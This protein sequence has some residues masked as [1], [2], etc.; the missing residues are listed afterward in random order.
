VAARA[1]W[2]QY[3]A[4]LAAFGMRPGLERVAAL[5]EALGRPQDTFRAVHIVGTNGKSS[6]TRYVAAILQAAGLQVGAYLSPHISGFAERV[7]IGGQ[8]IEEAD[9]GHAVEQV[10]A[11]THNLPEELGETTQFE[12]LTVA[13]LLAFAEAGVEAAAVE[14][15]LGGRLDATNVLLAPVV[16]LTNVALEHADVLGNTREL[17]FAEKAAVIKGGD[18]VFGPLDSLEGVARAVCTAAHARPYF[19]GFDVTVEG[20]PRRFTV[21]TPSGP[22]EGLSVPT[23]ALYQLTNAALA[24][25]AAEL[26]L[27]CHDAGVVR[28]ALGGAA[29]PGRLQVTHRHPLVLADG[30]HNPAG[31]RSLLAS[32]AFIDWPR[33]RVAVLAIMRDK[34]FA[35]MLALLEPELDAL[36]CTQATE[37][38]SLSA[39]ELQGAAAALT[40]GA[41]IEAVADPHR[42]LERAVALA[43]ER[44]SVLLTGS[45]YLL[46]DVHDVLQTS[47]GG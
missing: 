21:I 36:I 46:E 24:V 32:L 16:V 42:A 6:T 1:G 7:L 8:P 23:E 26:L 17:I 45:L 14:A 10:R 47:R 31:I 3:L 34:A 43:G 12:V 2:E 33:P 28:T 44:G 39:A 9:F 4:S 29:V 13:A 35:E 22:Y 5:L 18:A 19:F 38:R 27:G 15:G 37:A 40:T 20:E 11:L 25:M 41:A 30:A